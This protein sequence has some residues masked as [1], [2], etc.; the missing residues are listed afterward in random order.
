[1]DGWMG[2]LRDRGKERKGDYKR[3]V[4]DLWLEEE[5]RKEEKGR[6]ENG[7]MDGLMNRWIDIWMD[8]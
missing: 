2:R 3:L 4:E 7:W 8:D 5:E 1:M 6:K